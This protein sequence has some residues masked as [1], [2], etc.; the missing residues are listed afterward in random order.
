M[1]KLFELYRPDA[2]PGISEVFLRDYGGMVLLPNIEQLKQIPNSPYKGD[3]AAAS[4]NYS[5]SS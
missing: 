5:V 2:F 1:G 4:F 3:W